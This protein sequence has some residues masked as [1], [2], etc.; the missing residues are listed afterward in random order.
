MAGDPIGKLSGES[1]ESNASA[2]AKQAA[3]APGA[4]SRIH[5]PSLDTKSN[6]KKW[7]LHVKMRLY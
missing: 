4:P 3:E 7:A 1:K 6:M 2:I 5:L